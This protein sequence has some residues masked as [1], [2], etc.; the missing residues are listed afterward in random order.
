MLDASAIIASLFADERT[1][2][3]IAVR[4]RVAESGACVPEHW[5]L[6]V[7]NTLLM[8]QRRGRIDAAERSATIQDLGL[9]PLQTDE[10]TNARAW[11]ATLNLAE[12]HRLTVYDAAYLEL[13][14]RTGLPLASLDGDLNAAA[15]K[16]GVETLLA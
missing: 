15:G 9:L 14:L 16:S 2:A 4:A 3:V 13:A 10:E 8:A 11:H 6:E 7:A 5:W 12:R 1:P